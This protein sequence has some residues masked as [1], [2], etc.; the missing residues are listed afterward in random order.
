MEKAQRRNAAMDQKFLF[1]EDPLADSEATYRQMSVDEIVNG[2]EEVR[3][4]HAHGRYC[5]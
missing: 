1:R 3:R 4:A 5:Q 2:R